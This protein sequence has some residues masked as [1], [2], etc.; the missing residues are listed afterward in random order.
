MKSRKQRRISG[1]LLLF[2]G[3]IFCAGCGGGGKIE[4]E[5]VFADRLP[6]QSGKQG[7]FRLSPRRV[8]RTERISGGRDETIRIL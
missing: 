8:R 1:I 3:L 6:D 5:G 7:H 4:Y 2:M